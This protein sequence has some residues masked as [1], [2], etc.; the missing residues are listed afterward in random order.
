[1][2]FKNKQVQTQNIHTTTAPIMVNQGEKD[3]FESGGIV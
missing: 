3:P 2:L 1:M